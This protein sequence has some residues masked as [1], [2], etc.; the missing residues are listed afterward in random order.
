MKINRLI[1]NNFGIYKGIIEYDFRTSEGKN[2][3]LINGKNG[4]GKTT[5]LNAFKIALYGPYYLGYKTKVQEYYKF[6]KNRI[7]AY[8]LNEG[9]NKASLTIDF[10]ISEKGLK[11][12]YVIT[13]N[14]EIINDVPL[15]KLTIY[16]NKQMLP[17]SVALNFIDKMAEMISPDYI[18]IFFFDGEKIDQLLVNSKNQNYIMTMFSKLFNLDLFEKL[19]F[20]LKEYLNQKNIFDQLTNVE[21]KYEENLSEK[22]RLTANIKYLNNKKSNLLIEFSEL[23]SQLKFEEQSFKDLGGL[24]HEEK[25]EIQKQISNLQNERENLRTENKYIVQEFLP[26]LM[27][28]NQLESLKIRFELERESNDNKIF[29][30][31][32]NSSKFKN[33][34]FSKSN[35]TIEELSNIA[36]EAFNIDE[37]I[38]RIHD[39]S[40]N[41][42][43]SLLNLINEIKGYNLSEI[44]DYYIYDKEALRKLNILHTKLKEGL[45][46]AIDEYTKIVSSLKSKLLSIENQIDNINKEVESETQSLKLI[47]EASEKLFSEIKNSKKDESSYSLVQDINI[48]ISKYCSETRKIKLKQLES[49][50]TKL[51]KSLIRKEDFIDAIKINLETEQFTIFNK[52]GYEVPEE[53]LS[54]GE[55]QI[56][57]L[58]I[59][60]GLLKISNQ[61]IPI[62]FDTLL[63]RLDKTH[64]ENIIKYFLHELG[65]QIIILATDTEID[66]NYKMILSPYI[67]KYYEI[68]YDKITECVTLESKEN[69]S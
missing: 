50:I 48:V 8:S 12:N 36:N 2:I 15:E 1:L 68:N 55:R 58:S 4:A 51:F 69:Q 31:K 21:K 52:L 44:Y 7:N 10:L 22:N 11:N 43:S 54:A 26:F 49:T 60:W 53:N 67:S 61:K 35:M 59:L 65:D 34:L 17:V 20:D 46:D 25:Q 23:T 30:E 27:L 64:K 28:S 39:L 19:S 14:W 3:I 66:E 9:D 47:I 45:D 57:V 37:T 16:K 6:I 40:Y 56:F 24:M 32:I 63:G 29:K 41:E 13:R 5:L 42:E 62:I 33:L 18:D 38:K